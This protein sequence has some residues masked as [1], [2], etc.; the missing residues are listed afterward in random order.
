MY[1]EHVELKK[2]L[3]ELVT[4]CSGAVQKDRYAYVLAKAKAKAT[5]HI[6]SSSLF[7]SQHSRCMAA[8]FSSSRGITALGKRVADRIW[9]SS[10]LPL[11]STS[12]HVFL[13][14]FSSTYHCLLIAS[15]NSSNALALSR[16]ENP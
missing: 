13:S 1:L 4:T 3:K 15:T 11:S 9:T 8:T 6:L 10:P 16:E 12:R 14:S 5:K 7:F 2:A